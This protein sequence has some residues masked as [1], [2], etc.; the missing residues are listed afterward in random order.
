[1]AGRAPA[2]E[3]AARRLGRG[4]GRPGLAL[5][6]PVIDPAA[7]RLCTTPRASVVD[8][9]TGPQHWLTGPAG[10]LHKADPDTRADPDARLLLALLDASAGAR[11]GLP[12]AA[13]RAARAMSSR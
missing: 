7:R 11:P 8:G 12:A 5:R 4:F 13:W 10:A 3:I 2:W 6:V 9:A 1:M